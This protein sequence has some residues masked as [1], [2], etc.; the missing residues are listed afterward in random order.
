MVSKNKKVGVRKSGKAKANV[1]EGFQSNTLQKEICADLQK[2]NKGEAT[3]KLLASGSGGASKTP[4]TLSAHS[5]SN[6]NKS[7]SLLDVGYNGADLTLQL[8][9]QRRKQACLKFGWV[10]QKALEEASK[11]FMMRHPLSKLARQR[12]A[13]NQ[14]N[15]LFKPSLKQLDEFEQEMRSALLGEKT[16]ATMNTAATS[17]KTSGASSSISSGSTTP[18]SNIFLLNGAAGRALSSMPSG[19]FNSTTNA[20][21]GATTTPSTS[22]STTTTADKDLNAPSSKKLSRAAKLLARTS[23]LS[24]G[25][26]CVEFQPKRQICPAKATE[27][28][29]KRTA[30]EKEQAGKKKG[31]K[32]AGIK[33]AMKAGGSSSKVK[34]VVRKRE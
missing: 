8:L 26:K 29:N 5:A 18:S 23:Q 6:I 31:K 28:F 24:K 17:S 25:G 10:R 34:K 9:E 4:A 15:S 21:Q 2:Y 3:T 16:N 12:L 27:I 22:T 33:I 7:D 30:L 1:R 20:A 11:D 14:G 32:K 19:L 13:A